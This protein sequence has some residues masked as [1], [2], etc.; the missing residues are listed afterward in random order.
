MIPLTVVLDGNRYTR[1][2]LTLRDGRVVTR[3]LYGYRDTRN[4]EGLSGPMV[5]VGGYEFLPPKD[6]NRVQLRSDNNK[7]LS[8]EFV[9]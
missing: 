8:Y 5:N 3:K 4:Y 1:A 2:R 6:P 9:S 7:I